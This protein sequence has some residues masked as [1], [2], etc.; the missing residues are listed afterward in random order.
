[1]EPIYFNKQQTKDLLPYSKLIPAIEK[2]C[3]D[4]AKG[5]IIS[6]NRLVTPIAK[7]VMLSMPASASD[8]AITKLINICPENP[9]MGLETING[10]LV[11]WHPV[12]GIPQFILD[13][14]TITAKRTA[15]VS[16]VGIKL[17]ASNTSVFAIYGCGIQGLNHLEALASQYPNSTVYIIGSTIDK[18][19]N[20]CKRHQHLPLKLEAVESVPSET[21]VVITTT[22][23]LKPIYK[24]SAQSGRLIIAVGVFQTDRAEIAAETVKGSIVFVDD[25]PSAVHEAGDIIQAQINWDDVHS[26]EEAIQIGVENINKNN[27]PILFKSVGCAAWDLAACRVVQ[28][29]LTTQSN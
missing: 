1:M 26:L 8:I 19:I 2:A 7:G 4:Y 18:A 20:F 10:Q 27:T 15:A 28:E 29:I 25:L 16:M 9:Q 12:T 11:I 22:T 24:E 14:P 21:T 6:P 5:E 13:A 17:F 23:S 3:L